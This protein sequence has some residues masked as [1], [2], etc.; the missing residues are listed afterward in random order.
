MFNIFRRKKNNND[1]DELRKRLLEVSRQN[2]EL[3]KSNKKEE[4]VSSAFRHGMS[5][6]DVSDLIRRYESD[7][8]LRTD[9]RAHA[10]YLKNL[11]E[12]K[13]N[14]HLKR[15]FNDLMVEQIREI[16][17][18]TENWEQSLA[19]KGTFNGIKLVWD[20]IKE[21]SVLYEDMIKDSKPMQEDENHN[22]N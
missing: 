14:E 1:S 11:H 17:L 9:R 19:A 12:L 15:L 21:L 5:S 13:D 10:E 8:V 6:I 7:L 2:I 4:T 3:I 18:N 16:A 22:Y 20:S